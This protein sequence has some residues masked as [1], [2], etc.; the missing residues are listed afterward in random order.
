MLATRMR[1]AAAGRGGTAYRYFRCNVTQNNGNAYLSCVE[2]QVM[3]GASS[4]PT[5]IGNMTSNTAPS[6]LVASASTTAAGD[7]PWHA[8]NNVLTGVKWQTNSVQTGWLKIDLGSGNEQV[9]T[10]FKYTNQS[11]G[12]AAAR[13]PNDFTFEGSNNDSDW[14][15]L[16]TVTDA[17]GWGQ[18][19]TR[20]YTI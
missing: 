19:E 4:Y 11:G 15:V 17:T 6:P 8:F 12:D 16:Y 1:M 14:D 9:A 18:N 7:D 10:A 3:V 5:T 13:A 2:F 20:T